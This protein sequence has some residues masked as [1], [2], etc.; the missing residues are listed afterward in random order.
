MDFTGLIAKWLNNE[1][2][3][4]SEAE[5]SCADIRDGHFI[6]SLASFWSEPQGSYARAF[7]NQANETGYSFT[8]DGATIEG[9]MMLALPIRITYKSRGSGQEWR[10]EVVH[11]TYK[12]N[13]FFQKPHKISVL[14][15]KLVGE[16]AT[17]VAAV[18]PNFDEVNTTDS[19]SLGFMLSM[20]ALTTEDKPFEQVT[21]NNI[22]NGYVA[23]QVF[24]GEIFFLDGIL[25]D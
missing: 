16:A 7:I 25:E 9:G 5:P 1:L 23:E 24:E 18:V 12:N 6:V 3:V 19:L 13:K 20:E 21:V 2:G 10:G 17:R 4:P 15:G 22:K 8:Q 11:Q 14:G